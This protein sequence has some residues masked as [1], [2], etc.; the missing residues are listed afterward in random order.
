MNKRKVA[1]VLFAAK[2]Y[3]EEHGWVRNVF[4]DDNG[5][6]CALGAIHKVQR[7]AAVNDYTATAAGKYLTAYLQALYSPNMY[8]PTY[9]DAP[10]RKEK[11]ILNLL[12][13]AACH[14]C[15]EADYEERTARKPRAKRP[16]R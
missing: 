9:N 3:I 15:K 1:K 8:V 16:A 5:R 2:K 14:A 11:D 12:D 4:E 6:V 10:E 7:R 13:A